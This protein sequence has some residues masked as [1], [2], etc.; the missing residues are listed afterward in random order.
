MRNYVRN[1]RGRQLCDDVGGTFIREIEM[2]CIHNPHS[3]GTQSEVST[4]PDTQSCHI[5]LA[6]ERRYAIEGHPDGSQSSGSNT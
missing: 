5:T 1:Y 6:Q 3:L 4:K 2:N